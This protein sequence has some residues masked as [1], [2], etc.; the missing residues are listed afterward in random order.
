M[1]ST[2]RC[3]KCGEIKPATAIYFSRDQ[4][5]RDGLRCACK[6]C[7]H[8]YHRQYRAAHRDKVNEYNKQWHAD[9]LEKA[10]ESS[11]QWHADNREKTYEYA[12]QYRAAHRDR[13]NEYNKQWRD[14]H[15]DEQRRNNMRYQAAHPDKVRVIKQRHRARKRGAAGSHTADDIKLIF[16]SQRGRCWWCGCEVGEN[17]HVDHRIPLSKGGSNSPEN[18]VVSCPKCNWRKNDK[19]PHEWNGRLL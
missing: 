16:E 13:A 2:K 10:R 17:Y 7:D 15:P 12:R 11:K 9:N 18:L 4:A 8:E 19:L 14:A 5:R 1:D 6:V 3:T